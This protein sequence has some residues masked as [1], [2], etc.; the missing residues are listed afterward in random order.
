MPN[1]YRALRD[2]IAAG[3][4][5]KWLH[6]RKTVVLPDIRGFVDVSGGRAY[7][8][9]LAVAAYIAAASPDTI[10][11]LLADYDAAVAERDRLT[12]CL[13]Y[14]QHRAEHKDK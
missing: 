13:R 6:D 7:D 5:G 11:A 2:A 14:E 9:V 3:P 4:K 10:R 12:A 1:D 8:D